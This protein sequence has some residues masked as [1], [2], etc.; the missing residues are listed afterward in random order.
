MLVQG[1]SLVHLETKVFNSGFNQWLKKTQ[2]HPL[3]Q[4]QSWVEQK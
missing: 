1:Q 2:D 3:P 4:E